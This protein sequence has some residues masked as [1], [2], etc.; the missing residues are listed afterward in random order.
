MML[1]YP[2]TFGVFEE[3]TDQIVN[4]VR[5]AGGLVYIDGANMNAHFFQTSPGKFG[6]VCHLN[7]HKSFCIPHG[8]GGPGHGPILCKEHLI[9]FL[10]RNII[11]NDLPSAFDMNGPIFT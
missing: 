1:T 6:D 7:L 2:S 8:G 4:A 3:E 5:N 11:E 9:P 10:P